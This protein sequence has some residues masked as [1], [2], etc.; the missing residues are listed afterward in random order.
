MKSEFISVEVVIHIDHESLEWIEWFERQDNFVTKLPGR[1][2]KWFVYFAPIPCG[3]ANSTIQQLCTEIE[4]LP[5]SVKQCWTNAVRRVFFIGYRAGDEWPAFTDQLSLRT[6]KL[7]TG[8]H[9]EIELVI[10]PS[11]QPET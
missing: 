3:D 4:A 10:Y 6:L 7:V 9:A 1:E 2:A 8:L 5:E 11:G